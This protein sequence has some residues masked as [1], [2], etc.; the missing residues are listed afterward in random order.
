MKLSNQCIRVRMDALKVGDEFKHSK[1]FFGIYKV[2][3]I[4]PNLYGGDLPVIY[5]V[6]R[7]NGEI[8]GKIIERVGDHSAWVM[9]NLEFTAPNDR[10]VSDTAREWNICSNE[11]PG[12]TMSPTVPEL[13]AKFCIWIT[14]LPFKK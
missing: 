4:K 14:V 6:Q 1:D 13:T 8:T 12:T 11:V 9:A 7:I 2:I 10:E 5:K 3:E